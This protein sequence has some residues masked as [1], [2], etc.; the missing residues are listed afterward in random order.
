MK[1]SFI[2]PGY[3]NLGIEYLS[4]A[5][6]KAGHE[7]KLIFDPVLFS[8]SGGI[9]IPYLSR[10]FNYSARILN[11]ISSFAPQLI[12]FSCGTDNFSWALETAK[13]IKSSFSI[14]IIFGGVHATS[15]PEKV[16][17]QSCIDFVCL[18]EGE[19]A[20]VELAQEIED[21]PGNRSIKNI[22]LK[23]GESIICNE[24]RP[25]KEDLDDISFPDKE[26]YYRKYRFMFTGYTIITSRGCPHSCSYCINSILRNIYHNKGSYLRR[27]SEEN[28]IEELKVAKDRYRPKFIHFCDEVFTCDKE[29]LTKFILLYKKDINLPFACYVSPSF[30][31][32][33]T[34]GLLKEGGC[35]KAQMGVQ[36]L[37]EQKRRNFLNRHYSN[38]DIVRIIESFKKSKIYLTCDNI[39][40]LPGEDEIDLLET[41]KFYLAN[42]PNHMEVFWLKYYPATPIVNTAKN[43][44]L[45]DDNKINDIENGLQAVGIARGGDT[46]KAEFSRFQL[47]LNLLQFLPKSLCNFILKKRIYR[48]FPRIRPIFITVF[49]RIFNRA[50][51]DLYTSATFRRYFYFIRERLSI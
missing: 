6:R 51:F 10:Y 20:I 29:W 17:G 44:G 9:N 2:Y 22:W 26:L 43:M 31:D 48:F 47:F 42:R 15:V 4:S 8:D 21:G 35:Y 16:I 38:D 24:V 25:L 28:V 46:Y 32:E 11:E 36:T 14:P 12:C 37:N 40:G 33:E 18:G 34:I 27:R 19:E 1:I 13:K 45:I 30:A 49:F 3:E 5:L 41:V 7:T 39:F 23:D 50:K